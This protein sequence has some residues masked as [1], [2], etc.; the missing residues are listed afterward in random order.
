MIVWRSNLSEEDRDR[1][2]LQ[3]DFMLAKETFKQKNTRFMLTPKISLL[4]EKLAV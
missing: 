1:D 3:R 2:D 4:A